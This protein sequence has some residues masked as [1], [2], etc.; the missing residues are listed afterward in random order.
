VQERGN[1]APPWRTLTPDIR[2]WETCVYQLQLT[3]QE[4]ALF[5]VPKG[6]NREIET[7]NKKLERNFAIETP[8]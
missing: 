5:A 3:A 2:F 4:E 8:V 6:S 7:T 1:R